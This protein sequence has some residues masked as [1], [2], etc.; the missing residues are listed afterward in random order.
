[1]DWVNG[2]AKLKTKESTVASVQILLREWWGREVDPRQRVTHWTVG[3]AS[4]VLTKNELILRT[5]SGLKLPV[6]VVSGTVIAKIARAV[7][8]Q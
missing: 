1:M 6:C 4:K 5:L 3:K 2:H 7:L 8:G